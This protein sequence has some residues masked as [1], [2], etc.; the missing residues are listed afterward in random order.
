MGSAQTLPYMTNPGSPMQLYQTGAINQAAD[1]S[2]VTF[3]PAMPQEQIVQPEV[4][5]GFSKS[6]SQT[7]Y[8]NSSK[9]SQIEQNTAFH[10]KKGSIPSNM[11]LQLTV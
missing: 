9:I 7:F 1:A 2:T 8:N 5:Y 11:P 10:R 3:V 6:P 4:V